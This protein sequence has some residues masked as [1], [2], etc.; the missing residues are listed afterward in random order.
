MYLLGGYTYTPE[1]LC[2][3]FHEQGVTLQPPGMSLEATHYL[4]SQGHHYPVKFCM[5]QDQHV[6]LFAVGF[7]PI[8]PQTRTYH[9]KEMQEALDLKE[10]LKLED[11]PFVMAVY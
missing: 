1:K 11:A 6:F 8:T 10:A 2:D 9:F 5:Y 4:K 7:I 3:F